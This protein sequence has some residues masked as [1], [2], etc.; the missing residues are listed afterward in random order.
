MPI[1]LIKHE[2]IPDCGSFEV[3]FSDGRAS[4]Y[5]YFEDNAS[6]RLRPEQLTRKQALDQAEA[7]AGVCA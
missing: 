6:R 2:V 3:Q 1:Q 4:A 7:F 5:F